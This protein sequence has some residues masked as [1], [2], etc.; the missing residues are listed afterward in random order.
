M[1]AAI[2]VNGG[3]ETDDLTGWTVTGA[4]LGTVEGFDVHS[5][6][7][8]FYGFDNSGFAT[9]SQTLTTTTGAVY[10]LS[11]WSQ[12]YIDV[13][14]NILRYQVGAGP[15]V[16]VPNTLTFA[17]TTGSFTASDL[18]TTLNFYYETDEGTGTWYLDDVTVDQSS[19]APVPEP[20]TLVVWARLGLVS[21]GFVALRKKFS[22]A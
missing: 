13:P 16:T 4:D 7:F 22:G 1:N 2:V 11:F 14:G 21:L 3:F 20:A 15:I 5:G 9:L 12:T 8:A 17:E 19:V 6:S 10:D 18:A